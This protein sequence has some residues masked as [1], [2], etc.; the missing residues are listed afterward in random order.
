MST[1][2]PTPTLSPITKALF[3]QAQQ[4]IDNKK[5]PACGADITGS[6]S[7]KDTCSIKEYKISGMCQECQDKT[8]G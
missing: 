5:C 2:L 4:S 8:F 1:E 6:D 7:F 3:P